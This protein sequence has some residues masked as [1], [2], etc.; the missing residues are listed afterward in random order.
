[1][2]SIKGEKCERSTLYTKEGEEYEEGAGG[3]QYQKQKA[4]TKGKVTAQLPF[5]L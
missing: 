5:E 2:R 4:K 3:R 1:M